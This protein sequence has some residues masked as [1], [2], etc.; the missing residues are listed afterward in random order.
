MTEEQ[1]TKRLTLELPADL[2]ERVKPHLDR[3]SFKAIC[4]QALDAWLKTEAK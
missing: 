2:Y 3:Q 4:I 1:Y